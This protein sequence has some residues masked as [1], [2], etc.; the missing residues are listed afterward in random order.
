MLYRA[1]WMVSGQTKIPDLDV[2]KRVQ[3]N[4]DRLQISMYH[5]LR[6]QAE[7]NQAV[8]TATVINCSK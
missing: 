1:S 5:S 6:K 2:V 7:Q 3:E 8:H 4:V